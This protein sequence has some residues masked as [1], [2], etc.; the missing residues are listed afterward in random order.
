MRA[1]LTAAL[2]AATIALFTASL[3]AAP[4]SGAV[5]QNATPLIHLAQ[6]GGYCGGYH[7]RRRVARATDTGLPLGR[8]L[9]VNRAE[10]SG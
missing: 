9:A 1:I 5:N 2:A 10:Q 6:Y 7:R 8:L 3:S 4:A